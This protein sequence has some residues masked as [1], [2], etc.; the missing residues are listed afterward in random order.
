MGDWEI[1]QYLLGMH[2]V[3]YPLYSL[4]KVLFVFVQHILFASYAIVF[5]YLMFYKSA[6]EL[7]AIIP[8]TLKL[9]SPEIENIKLRQTNLSKS[10]RKYF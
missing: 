7:E 6:L 8:D 5:Q 9:G 2:I 3:S 10:F 4:K 1:Q